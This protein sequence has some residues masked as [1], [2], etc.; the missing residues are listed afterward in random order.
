MYRLSSVFNSL[1]W[2]GNLQAISFRNRKCCPVL[3]EFCAVAIVKLPSILAFA[4]RPISWKAH[5]KAD[6]INSCFFSKQMILYLDDAFR[7]RQQRIQKTKDHASYS[8][9]LVVLVVLTVVRFAYVVD[10]G[11]VAIDDW[12]VVV[13]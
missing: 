9:N 13:F 11:C 8:F 10:S 7:D 3:C 6:Y 2:F 1:F 4:E 5:F 12:L